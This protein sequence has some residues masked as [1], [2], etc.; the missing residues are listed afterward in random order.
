[1]ARRLSMTRRLAYNRVLLTLHWLT[2][3]DGYMVWDDD[4]GIA[5]AAGLSLAKT[6]TA[7]RDLAEAEEIAVFVRN[8]GQRR[9][10]LIDPDSNETALY[11]DVALNTFRG[12]LTNHTPR[13]TKLVEYVCSPEFW[14][15]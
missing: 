14:R 4:Q 15:A 7:L 3:T 13:I 2:L 1:M 12:T 11:I 10:V 6:K 9:L 8:D 5:R